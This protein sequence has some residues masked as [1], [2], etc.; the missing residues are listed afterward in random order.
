MMSNSSINTYLI[1]TDLDGTFLNND[2]FSF[3]DNIKLTKK[4][5]KLGHHVIINSSKTFA[6]IH[7]LLNHNNLTLPV[8]CETGGGVYLPNNH[9]SSNTKQSVYPGY[10][11]FYEAPKIS[12]IESDLSSALM[13]FKDDFD[14]FDDLDKKE[15]ENLSNLKDDGLIL[16]SKRV[17]TKLIVWKS[18]M[19][20]LTRLTSV[21]ESFNLNIIKGARF[22]H[23]CSSFSK[24]KSMNLLASY[25][26]Q[27]YRKTL[28]KTIA[29]GDSSNDIDMLMQADISCIVNSVGNSKIDNKELL[30]NSIK[31]ISPAPL[32]WQECIREIVTLG[33]M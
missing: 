31:S 19:N 10:T 16:A 22:C 27:K 9:S 24:G 30:K 13:D 21:L 28:F 8:I 14:F 29:I 17:F 23:L 4:L 6:E 12:Q 2:D 33:D 20:K 18:N 11:S 32:G 26:K 25:Y 15:Q 1:F 3:G 5:L 7:D